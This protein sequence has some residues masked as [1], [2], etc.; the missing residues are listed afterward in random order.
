MRSSVYARGCSGPAGIALYYTVDQMALELVEAPATSPGGSLR[1][2]YKSTG[3]GAAPA[4]LRIVEIDGEQYAV[5]QVLPPAT[6]SSKVLPGLYEA[7]W[8]V[9]NAQLTLS[10]QPSGPNGTVVPFNMQVLRD[11]GTSLIA[12]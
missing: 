1:V 4:G 11:I 12:T 2:P 8:Q 6:G 3:H 7:V 9:G 5:G 10:P